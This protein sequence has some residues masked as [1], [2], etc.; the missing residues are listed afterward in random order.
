MPTCAAVVFPS[1][2]QAVGIRIH[3]L[4]QMEVWC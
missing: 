1:H 2:L 4:G 3:K